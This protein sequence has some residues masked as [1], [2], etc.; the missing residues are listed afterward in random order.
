MT[1][2]C[3]SCSGA[4]A[5]HEAY[6]DSLKQAA[7]DRA[8]DPAVAAAQQAPVQRVQPPQPGSIQL[9]IKV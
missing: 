5:N 8:N 3:S 4:S 6:M 2:S 9:D 7:K 1:S